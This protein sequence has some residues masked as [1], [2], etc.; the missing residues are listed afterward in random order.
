M[1]SL[2]R[3][4]QFDP[5]RLNLL[6]RKLEREIQKRIA[7]AKQSKR[8]GLIE[9]VRYFWHV[10]EPVTPLVEG[11]PLEA[12]CQHLEAITYGDITR[13]LINVPPGFMKSLL[14]NVFW[15]A[16]EWG[17]L[18]K[19]HLRYVSFS[20]SSSLTERDNE[21]FRDLIRSAPFQELWGKHFQIIKDGAVKITNDH[22]GWKLASS[23]G[24]VGTGERGDRVLLDDLHNV[25][26]IESETIR[27]ETTRW[28]RESITS[29]LNNMEK[30]CIIAI[31]Q[32]VHEADV[33][34]TIIDNE[35]GYCHLMI[36]ME[37]D[38]LRHCTTE[39]GWED[40]R[41]DEGELAW[42]ERFSD[43]VVDN[44]KRDL[45]PY[46]YSA[47]YAQSPSPRG[48]AI[49]VRDWWQMWDP[50]PDANGK[51]N[52]P[53]FD[54][55]LASVDTAFT[56]KEENDPSAMTVWGVFTEQAPGRFDPKTGQIWQTRTG[57]R[58]VML[59]NAWRKHLK[60]HMPLYDDKGIS[61]EPQPGEGYTS[62]RRRTEH[63]WG[64]VQWVGETCRY[65]HANSSRPRSVDRLI[66]EAK[67]SGITAVQEMERLY[68]EDQWSTVAEPVKGDKVARGHAVVPA[69]SQGLIYAPDERQR[70]H[71]WV[72][73]VI[74][75]MERFPKGKY[76]DVV[77]SATQ[78]IKHLREIGLIQHPDERV[79][80]ELETM[81]H[82][83]KSE[84]LY[85]V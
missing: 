1:N 18:N 62:W 43:T 32:R 14:T 40:P 50:E 60:M 15:P 10:L 73:L 35:M 72:E 24:G 22:T 6:E 70:N 58:K 9:F 25:K 56:E 28:F 37:H 74:T 38:L 31:G 34:G 2:T 8:G 85:D 21:R 78:A 45:G 16:W 51:K 7:R 48:G 69:W 53:P 19:P 41:E 80:Q 39:I 68:A 44:L 17:P 49:F 23:V 29:R 76:R 63:H 71:E 83:P 5:S 12:V 79:A 66:I 55:I 36:P 4:Q 59:I 61:T 11:W 75:D 52:Y 64:L 84:P 82:R 65:A 3:S 20:Y 46:A 81:K 33:S 42:D 57:Q 77:D 47:Q 67:A 27:Q 30:S 54:F 13:L 26:D